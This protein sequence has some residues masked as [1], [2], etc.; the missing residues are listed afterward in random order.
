MEKYFKWLRESNRPKHIIVG[1]L[2]GLAFGFDGAF[3]AAASAETKDWLWNGA[4]GGKLGWLKGNSFDWLDFAA[5]ML[6]GT[7][8]ALIRLLIMYMI[9]K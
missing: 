4:R 2:I 5:T 9:W 7:I 3:V 6:G 1:F 8:G